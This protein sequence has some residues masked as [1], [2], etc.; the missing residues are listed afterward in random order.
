M[1]TS[2]S[3]ENVYAHAGFQRVRSVSKL[4]GP[5]QS[6]EQVSTGCHATDPVC[7]H[8]RAGTGSLMS[9]SYWLRVLSAAGHGTNNNFMEKRIKPGLIKSEIESRKRRKKG[10]N[11][12]NKSRFEWTVLHSA[13]G[14]N[15]LGY[16]CCSYY[17][18]VQP[19]SEKQR[20]RRPLDYLKSAKPC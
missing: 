20:L 11:L 4:T 1:A 5:K 8:R 15:L 2:A 6:N 10:R 17:M 12:G 14:T 18:T 9:L 7:N 13:I 16:F 19:S 3:A